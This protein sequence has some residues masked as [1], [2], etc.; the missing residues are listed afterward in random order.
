MVNKFQKTY[1]RLLIAVKE[2]V[3]NSSPI[4]ILFSENLFRPQYWK[5]ALPPVFQRAI[6]NQTVTATD[7][8]VRTKSAREDCKRN[9]KDFIPTMGL[10]SGSSKN[11]L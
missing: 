3:S 4:G 7:G 8:L 1:E 9:F 5:Q 2:K 6:W 10:F 11:A